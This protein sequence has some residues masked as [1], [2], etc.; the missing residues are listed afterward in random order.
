M[1]R[2][3]ALSKHFDPWIGWD[4]DYDWDVLEAIKGGKKKYL[5]RKLTEDD[6]EICCM[7]LWRYIE[8]ARGTMSLMS[9]QVEKLVPQM[10]LE[11]ISHRANKKARSLQRSLA[12]FDKYVFSYYDGV[13][14]MPSPWVPEDMGAARPITE[15]LTPPQLRDL[16][17]LVYRVAADSYWLYMLTLRVH[18]RES[19]SSRV[20]RWADYAGA[21]ASRKMFRPIRFVKR[22][23]VW[24]EWYQTKDRWRK[25]KVLPTTVEVRVR[26]RH[27][28]EALNLSRVYSAR[29]NRLSDS[30]EA[31]GIL[32]T[33]RC[34]VGA[35]KPLTGALYR[36]SPKA[37]GEKRSPQP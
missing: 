22:L 37:A 20:S 16:Q 17:S 13:L 27:V 11:G 23:F 1:H 21:K 14:V 24:D 28:P 4:Y 7:R 32:L 12:E 35:V 29:L 33:F 30:P 36:F 9:K 6:W 19:L 25:W 2:L 8:S 34:R 3:E 31:R 26:R 5:K 18:R 15:V 10:E